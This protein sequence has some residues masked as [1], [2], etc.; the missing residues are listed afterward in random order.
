VPNIDFLPGKCRGQGHRR[1]DE[2]GIL[3]GAKGPDEVTIGLG[4]HR[5][6]IAG[7]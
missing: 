3:A 6:A 4:D 7:A 5:Y 2:A 1:G